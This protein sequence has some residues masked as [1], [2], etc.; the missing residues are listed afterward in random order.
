MVNDPRTKEA[1]LRVLRW[2]CG[3]LILIPLLLTVNILLT[4]DPMHRPGPNWPASVT[5]AGRHIKQPT[6]VATTTTLA[7]SQQPSILGQSV[8]FT[9]TVTPAG[10]GTPTGTV[11]F[12]EGAATL[13]SSA[14]SG[15]QAALATAALAVGSHLIMAA[16][17]G[18]T[19]FSASTS[20]AFTQNV[21]YNICLL[22]DPTKSKNS[23][24]AFPIKLQ[25]CDGGGRN[26][27]SPGIVLHAAGITAVSGFSGAA[28]AEANA[29]P[30]NDFRFDSTL[31]ST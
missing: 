11:T 7:S 9:A 26:L 27:S 4:A 21:S 5:F 23:G 19:N 31:G 13:G 6:I 18:D 29:N 28:D 22:Y 10:A 14:L 3:S 1:F 24:A 17:G 30:D 12:K 15:G 16:Y 8:A 25:L 20:A 2:I